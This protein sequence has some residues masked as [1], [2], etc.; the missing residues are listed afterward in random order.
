L[1]S[2]GGSGVPG[3]AP[4]AGVPGQAPGAGAVTNAGSSAA[5]TTATT[6]AEETA[7]KSLF[8]DLIKRFPPKDVLKIIQENDVKGLRQLLIKQLPENFRPELLNDVLDMAGDHFAKKAESAKK[9]LESATGAAALIPLLHDDLRLVV[10][11][12]EKLDVR[13]FAIR[14]SID[15]LF[16]VRLYA[17][18]RNADVKFDDIIGKT[19][20]FELRTDTLDESKNRL[21]EGVCSRIEQ[22]GVDD[23]NLSGYEVVLVPKVWRLTQRKNYRIYQYLSE[24]AAVKQ[25]LDEWKIQQD[26]RIDWGQYKPRKYR[27]QYDETDFA[28]VTRTLED[29][30]I[31]YFF[32]RVEDKTVMVLE[33]APHLATKRDPAIDYQNRPMKSTKDEFVTEVQMG[34][35]TRPG[36]YTIY[37]HDYR[38][39][40][41]FTLA[42]TA[43]GGLDDEAPLERF[44]YLP[45]AFLFVTEAGDTPSA[46]DRGVARH[47]QSEADKLAKKRHEAK[48]SAADVL[49]LT[50]NVHALRPG[51]V[52][53][54]SNHPRAD[55]QG[56]PLLVAAGKLA[57]T[58]EGGWRHSCEVRNA[59]L[60]YRPAL[61][62]PKP[63]AA[64]P[65][66]A[67]V[68]GPAGEEI[69]TDEFGRVRVQFHW[70][71]EGKRDH[72]A[73][74]W[75]HVNQPWAGTGFGGSNIPR[76][77]QEVI[78][79]F[80]SGDPDRPII[81]GRYFTNTTKV[82]YTL[83]ANKTQGGFKSMSSPGGGG[84]NE[85]MFED[86]KGGELVRFQAEKDFTGL[87][88]NN[89][90]MNI[91][92]NRTVATGVDDRETVGRDQYIQVGGDQ[93][94]AVG[95][96]GTKL[97]GRH[98]VQ[99][100]VKGDML[101]FA[102]TKI[103]VKSSGP[104]EV[105]LQ[106]GNSTIQMLPDQ[107]IIQSPKV[108]INPGE[109][110]PDTPP[111]PPLER[112]PAPPVGF[113][114]GAP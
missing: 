93:M 89:S 55:L 58:T 33:D 37:D 34:S 39:A 70:D 83:P 9:A 22:V 48:R 50:T 63:K 41:D 81:M 1:Q 66:S 5:T 94:E 31:A 52:I 56:T 105:R 10:A 99:Q 104:T 46:D 61:I 73:G 40:G 114:F 59:K 15:A 80:L 30:G 60:P 38:R 106:C 12:G 13:E 112:M 6:A 24:P 76:V 77:G 3:Q 21:W 53:E 28:F 23:E 74:C 84:F 44:Q 85:L 87:V 49:T 8:D 110:L 107:I 20:S 78:V 43:G 57:G 95:R 88:K 65:E 2:P 64:G 69:H 26:W 19:A 90:A 17:L 4:G 68:V 42:A 7:K 11:S 14:E 82:P 113:F 54:I 109:T 98:F 72:A 35:R 29:A 45:G 16:E 102:K 86:K 25:L 47:D 67:T 75:I 97:V 71:R 32:E 62:T 27:V 51:M 108:H 18:T 91:G 36:K 111:P 101:L 103:L 79:E 96:D 100:S 92:A